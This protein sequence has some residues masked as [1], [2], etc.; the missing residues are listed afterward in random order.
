MSTSII[1]NIMNDSYAAHDEVRTPFSSP[2]ALPYMNGSLF[3]AYDSDGFRGQATHS[4]Y[5]SESPKH[6]DQLDV[7]NNHLLNNLGQDND[8]GML[9]WSPTS[10][11]SSIVASPASGLDHY[12]DIANGTDGSEQSLS[13]PLMLPDMSYAMPSIGT[14]F[15]RVVVRNG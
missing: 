5:N 7:S 10:F 6:V 14:Q 8:C 3:H 15:P 4:Y 2:S 12:Q 13:S 9:D 1:T 11:G